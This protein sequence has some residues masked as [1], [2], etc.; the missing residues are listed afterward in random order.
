MKPA[1]PHRYVV[2]TVRELE[3]KAELPPVDHARQRQRVERSLLTTR[4]EE[5]A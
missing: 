4:D 3:R 2:P 5:R 1:E